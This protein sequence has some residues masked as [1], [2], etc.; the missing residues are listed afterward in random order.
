MKKTIVFICI[1]LCTFLWSCKAQPNEIPPDIPAQQEKPSTTPSGGPVDDGL[2]NNDPIEDNSSQNTKPKLSEQCDK[3]FCKANSLDGGLL[4]IVVKREDAYPKSI[5]YFGVIK[6]NEW[7]VELTPNCPFIDDDG[8]WIGLHK[9]LANTYANVEFFSIGAGCFL[10]KCNDARIVYK[11]E[12][13]V[14]FH[15]SLGAYADPLHG[16]LTYGNIMKDE[17]LVANSSGFQLLNMNTGVATPIDFGTRHAPEWIHPV[18]DGLFLAEY[19]GYFGE[20]YFGFFD[21][22][23]NF[24]I[25]LAAFRVSKQT[26]GMLD[27]Y[28]RFEDGKYTFICWNESGVPYKTT[29]DTFGAIIEQH[30]Q[31]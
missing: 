30:K 9:A 17:F 19:S 29:I 4:E 3:V 20:Y 14:S 15:A 6:N 25:D 10:Y 27:E 21:T 5:F 8:R 16:T 1:I 7:L 26:N 31:E 23:G 2:T 13:G 28:Q 24:V 12:T 22:E 18:S 11:P